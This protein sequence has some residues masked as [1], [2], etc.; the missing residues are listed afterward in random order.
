MAK[1]TSFLCRNHTGTIKPSAS[2]NGI[3]KRRVSLPLHVD[4]QFYGRLTFWNSDDKSRVVCN[5]S[6]S[7]CSM[8]LPKTLCRQRRRGIRHI[9]I[10][11]NF[12]IHGIAIKTPVDDIEQRTFRKLL[13]TCNE[14]MCQ[15]EFVRQQSL[16]FGIIRIAKPLLAIRPHGII[17]HTILSCCG[18]PMLA[19]SCSMMTSNEICDIL[20]RIILDETPLPKCA[21]GGRF[22][23]EEP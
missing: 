13:R 4:D 16:H 18:A 14:Q 20:G 8:F 6:F 7:R 2:G 3:R 5:A 11:S 19:R 17:T 23:W 1:D 15:N 21:H 9:L 10:K 22:S 12:A